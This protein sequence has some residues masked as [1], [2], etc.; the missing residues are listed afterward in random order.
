MHSFTMRSGKSDC[1]VARQSRNGELWRA[2]ARFRGESAL[3]SPWSVTPQDELDVRAAPLRLLPLGP[4]ISRSAPVSRAS[5]S[6]IVPSCSAE[7]TLCCGWSKCE[8]D[9]A[10]L[11]I[12]APGDALAPV[13]CGYVW[14]VDATAP[15]RSRLRS[16]LLARLVEAH[17]VVTLTDQANAPQ[18]AVLLFELAGELRCVLNHNQGP[19]LP[20]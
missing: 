16:T 5:G 14:G 19:R 7:Q 17:R 20:A 12:G 1:A 4:P 10:D 3:T 15:S 13:L 6:L 18:R 11:E 2:M 8:L 9:G